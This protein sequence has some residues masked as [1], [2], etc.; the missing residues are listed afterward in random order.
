[1]PKQLNGAKMVKLKN[2][3]A[4]SD[5]LPTFIPENPK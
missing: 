5:T 2:A 1:M 4:L 3:C